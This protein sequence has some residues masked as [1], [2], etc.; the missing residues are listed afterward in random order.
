M[1][2]RK[3]VPDFGIFEQHGGGN[4]LVLQQAPEDSSNNH[5][6]V[7]VTAGDGTEAVWLDALVASAAQNTHTRIV[8]VDCCG[9]GT[10]HDARVLQRLGVPSSYVVRVSLSQVLLGANRE[11]D[12]YASALKEIST[13]AKGAVLVLRNADFLIPMAVTQNSGP[14]VARFLWFVRKV[15]V[16][17]HTVY[18]H[19]RAPLSS[20]ISPETGHDRYA[21][22]AKCAA[23]G[24]AHVA[25]A[26]VSV[27]ALG[28]G[29][30]ADVTGTVT[31]GRG[32][33]SGVKVATGTYQYLVT[34]DGVKIFYL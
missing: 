2:T 3:L 29:R 16:L 21:V 11:E 33:G 34:H 9:S 24:V 31:I 5:S 13:V 19:M 10:D 20:G 27:R 22:A 7:L 17:A 12:V 15:G 4:G 1:L 26:V 32:G 28:T 25:Q 23:T 14:D 8:I 18:V 30:A 6:L